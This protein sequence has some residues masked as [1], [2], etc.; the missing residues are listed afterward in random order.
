MHVRNLSINETMIH[1]R[2][3]GRSQIHSCFR[4]ILITKAAD[5]EVLCSCVIGLCHSVIYLSHL[6]GKPTMWFPIRFDTNRAVQAQKMAEDGKL[7]IL[8]RRGIVLSM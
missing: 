7:W 6:V 8:E 2:L 1:P 4:R 3:Y 5:R